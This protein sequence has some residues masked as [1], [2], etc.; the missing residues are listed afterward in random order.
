[1]ALKDYWKEFVNIKRLQ[2]PSDKWDKTYSSFK[3]V[4]YSQD[5]AYLKIKGKR[6][7][8]ECDTCKAW[9]EKIVSASR[10]KELEDARRGRQRH[11][12]EVRLERLEYHKKRNQARDNSAN[13]LSLIIDGMDQAKTNLPH[14]NG[15]R[16]SGSIGGDIKTRIVGVIVHGIGVFTFVV[17][18]NV[19]G[20]ANENWTI[21]LRVLGLLGLQRLRRLKRVFIQMDNTHKDNK[22]HLTFA[23]ADLLVHLGVLPTLEFGFLPVGHT[24]EDIDQLFGVIARYLR[25]NPAHSLE[26]LATACKEAYKSS[27]NTA[28]DL[29]AE[30]L[31][32][33]QIFDFKSF[34]QSAPNKWRFNKDGLKGSDGIHGFLFDGLRREHEKVCFK[35][36]FIFWHFLCFQKAT[37]KVPKN[38]RILKTYFFML[39][40]L[41]S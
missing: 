20:D 16:N 13:Y 4:F 12:F 18:Q 40:Y 17:P 14:A 41:A 22:A 10:G 19:Q 32:R 31:H 24:H 28:V 29:H 15:S 26:Q 2:D 34:L 25:R 11:R 35:N 1:M 30:V 5:F 37:E 23:V 36:S 3:K 6:N 39:A 8:K 9:H 33:H 7:F 21:L 27:N 38:K